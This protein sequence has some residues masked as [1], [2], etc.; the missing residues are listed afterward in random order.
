VSLVIAH[1]TAGNLLIAAD[2]RAYIVNSGPSAK[3]AEK[4]RIIHHKQAA[5]VVA[6]AG[7]SRI[8]NTLLLDHA[9]SRAELLGNDTGIA[10][11]SLHLENEWV[12]DID[13]FEWN[14]QKSKQDYI[15][16]SRIDMLIFTAPQIVHHIG[17]PCPKLSHRPNENTIQ[18]RCIGR[19]DLI[20][21]HLNDHLSLQGNRSRYFSDAFTLASKLSDGVAP[22]IDIIQ[23]NDGSTPTLTRFLDLSDF[24]EARL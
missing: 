2:T 12:K 7:E 19:H 21:E 23:W 11:F 22:P 6:V 16:N 4:V 8:N 9:S 14:D 24:N 18:I 13:S 1:Q 10:E 5:F 15:S 17:G 3:L 20:K